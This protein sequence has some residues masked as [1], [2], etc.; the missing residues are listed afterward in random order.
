MKH[1]ELV[2]A[3]VAVGLT[4]VL[5]STRNVTMSAPAQTMLIAAF[6]VAVLVYGAFVF[7]ERPADEREYENSLFADKYAYVVGAGILT[8]G[9]IVQ[10]I[11]HTLD[12]WLPVA[13]A[14]M[15]AVKSITHYINK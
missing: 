10:T 5:L 15:V 7:N 14:S 2:L 3:F 9:I 8:L 12:I 13:L 6:T 4:I 11:D 1:K